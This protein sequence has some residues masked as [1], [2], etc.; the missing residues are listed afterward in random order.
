VLVMD[1]LV[2]GDGQQLVVVG[3]GVS[4]LLGKQIEHSHKLVALVLDIDV[5]VELGRLRTQ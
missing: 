3:E 4:G 1:V 5:F 2:F